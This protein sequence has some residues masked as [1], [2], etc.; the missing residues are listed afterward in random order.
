MG[1]AGSNLPEPG[2]GPATSSATLGRGTIM[3]R[4]IGIALVFAAADLGSEAAAAEE[5]T[6]NAEKLG[7]HLGVQAFS[8][9]RMTLFE[10]ID[11]IE[12]LG[13]HYLEAMPGQ[14]LSKE[15]RKVSFS[16]DAPPEIL[17]EV[18]AK[19][20]E[21]GVKLINY[22]V[23]PLPNDEAESRKVFE[24]A[25]TMGVET[26]VSEPEADALDLID[27]LCN[28][29][30]IN[31]AIHNHPAPTGYWDPDIVLEACKGRSK[32]IGA[33]VDT[34]HWMRS[35]VDVLEALK[36]LE[37]RILSFHFG[38]VSEEKLTQFLRRINEPKE[39]EKPPTLLEKIFGINNV[40][41][42]E[43]PGDMM[44][45]LAEIKRQGFKGVFCIESF[46][47]LSPDIAVKNMA[48]CIEYFDKAAAEL[49]G[50]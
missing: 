46:Y 30:G 48:G 29:Y 49:A 11:H 2:G 5:R 40:V 3:Y 13:L 43:G 47:E 50:N 17:E 9:Y 39:G 25:K 38:D 33:C 4:C 18:K 24:F 41:Y 28:E 31:V 32:R 8:F 36:K 15:N 45:W 1:G 12:A 6:A 42:G 21:A 10:T 37:G 44:A 35:Q 14:A 20:K 26:I 7:W 27:R 16:H 34:S 22:G 23:V 19:L